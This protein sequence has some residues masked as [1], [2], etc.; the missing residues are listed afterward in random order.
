MVTEILELTEYFVMV[1]KYLLSKKWNF[2]KQHTGLKFEA[3]KPK[4]LH[5]V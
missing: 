2:E 4:I 1:N 3:K 5:I